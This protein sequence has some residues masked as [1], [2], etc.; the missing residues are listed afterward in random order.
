MAFTNG[1]SER[2]GELRYGGQ[3]SSTDESS[4]AGF[5]TSRPQSSFFTSFQPP[6]T[7]SRGGLQRRFTTDASKM[8]N[9]PAF[10]QQYH[11]GAGTVR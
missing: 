4:F 3:R 2:M 8:S 5:T 6:S 10:G 7:D 1:L 11:M 9:A